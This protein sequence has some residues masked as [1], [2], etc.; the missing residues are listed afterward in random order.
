MLFAAALMTLFAALAAEALAKWERY[1]GGKAEVVG[2]PRR[3]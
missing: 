2:P 1:L 3:T